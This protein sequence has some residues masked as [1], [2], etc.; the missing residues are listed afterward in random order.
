MLETNWP[1]VNIR[2]HDYV[3]GPFVDIRTEEAEKWGKFFI[4]FY[5]VIGDKKELVDQTF[6]NGNNWYETTRKFYT[7]WY[8]EVLGFQ[9]NKI[10]KV[11]WDKFDLYNKRVAIWLQ[12]GYN[13][14]S[15]INFHLDSL[16]VIEEFANKHKCYVTVVSDFSPSLSSSN[17]N[18]SFIPMLTAKEASTS[19][20]ATYRIGVY[21]SE[22]NFIKLPWDDLKTQPVYNS[23]KVYYDNFHPRNVI[24]LNLTP[25]EIARDILFGFNHNDLS[26]NN[27]YQSTKSILT[28]KQIWIL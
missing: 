17:K 15:D 10:I 22:E 26:Y 7:N 25:T 18:I 3:H 21:A 14:T 8:I 2:Y 4:K 5:E 19:Y 27:Y 28:S 6:I 23:N 24:K 16:P 1:Q 13:N 11:A 9:N 12:N 20:Y